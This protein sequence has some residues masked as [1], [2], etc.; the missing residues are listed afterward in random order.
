MIL[1]SSAQHVTTAETRRRREK[2][3]KSRLSSLVWL[4]Y[5]QAIL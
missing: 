3:V 1:E 2:R 4:S 5:F